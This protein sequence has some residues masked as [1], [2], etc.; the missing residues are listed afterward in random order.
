MQQLPFNSIQLSNQNTNI[1]I[2]TGDV[3]GI[4]VIN[5]HISVLMISLQ[6][7]L[8]RDCMA[9]VFTN[10][11]Y[12]CHPFVALTPRATPQFLV[13]KFQLVQ[14]ITLFQYEFVWKSVFLAT[15]SLLPVNFTTVAAVKIEE[16]EEKKVQGGGGG[17]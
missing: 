15:D 11:H 17:G 8:Q 4:E 7:C 16:V 2:C 5:S 1:Y 13:S 14:K 9:H 12:C 6:C 10:F 3:V